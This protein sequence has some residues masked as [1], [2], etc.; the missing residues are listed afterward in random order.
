VE[1][2][3]ELKKAK[4]HVTSVEIAFVLES[5][6]DST[7][8]K[9]IPSGNLS[10]FSSLIKK[11]GDQDTF[12]YGLY[13]TKSTSTEE[14]KKKGTKKAREDEGTDDEQDE[15]PKKKQKKNEGP[16]YNCPY[17]AKPYKKYDAY[18]THVDNRA[19]KE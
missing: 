15:P 8:F 4:Y 12:L 5:T 16:P 18:A 2:L 13:R 6:A 11:D 1:L 14:P 10:E 7:S 19:C 17:C 9:V 3:R